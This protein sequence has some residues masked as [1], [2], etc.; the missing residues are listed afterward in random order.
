MYRQS[1]R[2]VLLSAPVLMLAVAGT[3]QAAEG[4]GGGGDTPS[5][6]HRTCKAHA[7]TQKLT[8][9]AAATFVKRCAN[10]P[11]NPASRKA[12]DKLRGTK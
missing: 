12:G 6:L 4:Q 8:Q 11:L 7:E 10:A 3:A 2:T 1:M 5:E 9:T